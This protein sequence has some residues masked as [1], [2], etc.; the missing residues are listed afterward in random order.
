MSPATVPPAM[1]MI[2]IYGFKEVSV[3]QLTA[4]ENGRSPPPAF[5]APREPLLIIF[6]SQPSS[7]L[8][9][10]LASLVLVVPVRQAKRIRTQQ[11]P[12]GGHASGAVRRPPHPVAP[13]PRTAFQ[14]RRQEAPKLPVL[15][16]P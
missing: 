12:A 7:H 5:R 6:D 3:A 10:S 2:L 1:M 9:P 11:G 14:K 16:F 13:A 4:R 8:L 15:V